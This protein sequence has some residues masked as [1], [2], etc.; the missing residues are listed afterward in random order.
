MLTEALATTTQPKK[1]KK[2]NSRHIM[3]LE[4][5]VNLILIGVTLLVSVNLQTDVVETPTDIHH[6]SQHQGRQ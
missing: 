2:P 1:E 5:V 4:I 6:T 3:Q